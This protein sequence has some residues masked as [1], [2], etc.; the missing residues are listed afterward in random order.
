MR[1]WVYILP[2]LLLLMISCRKN[3]DAPL[4][5]EATINNLLVFDNS[6]QT[7]IG[8]GF[9]FSEAKLVSTAENPKPDITVDSDGTNLF[10]QTNNL[11]ESFFQTG[12]YDNPASAGE[13]F[14][15]LT[16]PV[17]TQWS[18]WADM[19]E[20]NQIWIYRSG[21][22]HYAKIR[23]I[24]TISEVRDTRDYAECTFEWVYQPDGSLTFPAK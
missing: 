5:G 6:R 11:N 10:F 18:E 8:Y 20:A 7:Y 3:D 14:N 22:E 1:V 12:E 19:I 4:S 2:V 13:A 15:N 24:S 9:L 21:S 23:I 16:A 17:V